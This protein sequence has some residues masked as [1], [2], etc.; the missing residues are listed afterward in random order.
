MNKEK[1]RLVFCKEEIM[2][3]TH[4]PSFS[5]S[6]PFS[7][8]LS[9][10]PSMPFSFLT[11]INFS[12]FTPF[13]PTSTNFQHRVKTILLSFTYYFTSSHIRTASFKSYPEG[14]FF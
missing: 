1:K 5:L 10:L 12:Q 6:L 11:T 4:T 14:T 9:L 7:L 2:K 13:I 8:S 3:T